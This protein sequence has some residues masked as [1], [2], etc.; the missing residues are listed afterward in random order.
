MKFITFLQ[1]ERATAIFTSESLSNMSEVVKNQCSY[2]EIFM[3]A[4]VEASNKKIYLLVLWNLSVFKLK[5]T[6]K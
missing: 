2:V 5:V 4:T 1:Y 6:E 3:V